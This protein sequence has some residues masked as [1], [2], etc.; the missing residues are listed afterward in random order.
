MK[1]SSGRVPFADLTNQLSTLAISSN[2]DIKTKEDKQDSSTS[3]LSAAS[4][5]SI[6]DVKPRKDKKGSRKLTNR[7]DQKR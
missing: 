3:K 1:S 7:K 4:F 6:D 5:T 2:D